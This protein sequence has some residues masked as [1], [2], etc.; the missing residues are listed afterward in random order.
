MIISTWLKTRW[1][2]NEFPPLLLTAFKLLSSIRS[3]KLQVVFRPSHVL[4]IGSTFI[5]H[6]NYFLPWMYWKKWKKKHFGGLVLPWLLWLRGTQI[7]LGKEA[8]IVRIGVELTFQKHW[9][10]AH[11][12]HHLGFHGLCLIVYLLLMVES[13]SPLTSL[14]TGCSRTNLLWSLPMRFLASAPAVASVCQWQISK[15]GMVDPGHLFK[16]TI[17]HKL[18]VAGHP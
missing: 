14:G 4:D 7:C 17:S 16:P 18:Q 1:G 5:F 11:I 9:R 2:T 10:G 15:W 13:R 8:F 3:H 12:R 6:E